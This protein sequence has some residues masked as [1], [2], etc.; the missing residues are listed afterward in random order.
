MIHRL[1]NLAHSA[2]LNQSVQKTFQKTFRVQHFDEY[3]DLKF[4]NQK[5]R[6]K[7]ET[8][9]SRPSIIRALIIGTFW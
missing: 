9:V 2:G 8:F 3:D 1:A 4:P 5:V 7:V 6:S